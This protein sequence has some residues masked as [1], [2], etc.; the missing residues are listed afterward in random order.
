MEPEEL[1]TL[2]YKHV[3]PHG[4]KSANYFQTHDVGMSQD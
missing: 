3:T 2:I 4:V 1:C